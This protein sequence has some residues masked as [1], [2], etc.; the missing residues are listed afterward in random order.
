MLGRIRS[1]LTYANVIATI[2]LFLALGGSSYA[3]TVGSGSIRNNTIRSVDVRNGSLL[4]RDHRRASLGGRAIRES[5]LGTVPSAFTLK[6]TTTVRRASPVVANNGT[7]NVT[8]ECLGS[9][10]AIAGGGAWVIPGFQDGNQA[11]ALNAPLTASRPAPGTASG[12]DN[13]TGWQ[14]LG[15]NLSGANRQLVAYAICVPE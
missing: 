1:R 15:R 6:D 13:N 7:A 4:D 9:Q 2:A 8:A 10:K 5:R 11:S 14:V 3:L 12:T